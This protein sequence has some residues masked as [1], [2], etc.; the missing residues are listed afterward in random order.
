MG[1]MPLFQSE[2]ATKE[3]TVAWKLTACV[4]W[5]MLC[6]IGWICVFFLLFF[7]LSSFSDQKLTSES[8]A[9]L[10]ARIGG[11]LGRLVGFLWGVGCVVILSR[12]TK[13]KTSQLENQ[14]P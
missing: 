6:S 11:G 5:S 14:Q 12:P 13:R 7:L 8:G 9:D 10:G 1:L 4:L 3:R 2:W